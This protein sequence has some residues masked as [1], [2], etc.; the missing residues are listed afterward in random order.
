MTR[1]LRSLGASIALAL[2]LVPMIGLAIGS[3]LEISPTGQVRASVVRWGLT[4]SDPFVITCLGNSLTV[5]I[6]SVG[7]GT[8]AGVLAARIIRSRI[9]WHRGLAMLLV[10]LSAGCHPFF[11]SIGVLLLTSPLDE[12]VAGRLN[13]AGFWDEDCW[14]WL[15][16]VLSQFGFA[17]A[18]IC[19][20]TVRGLDRIR[21]DWVLVST[22]SGASRRWIWRASIWPLVRPTVAR[23]A[24]S[25]FSVLLIEPG[26]PIVLGLQRT[27]G[28]QV[29]ASCWMS[30]RADWPRA[31]SIA[32]IGLI[33]V[34]LVRLILLRWG[35]PDEVDARD[36][37]APRSAG[38]VDT[39]GRL[40]R[41]GSMAFLGLW[42]LACL[43]PAAAVFGAIGISNPEDL[44]L[45]GSLE[46]MV[47]PLGGS[48]ALGG[49]VAVVS[50]LIAWPMSAGRSG[51][52]ASAIIEAMPPLAIG[53]GLFGLVELLR[54]ISTF[55]PS[56]SVLD[57]MFRVIDL[58]RSPW[59][60]I[61]WGTSVAMLPW[62]VEASRQVRQ[63]D[64]GALQDLA[65]R[66]GDRRARSRTL[67]LA[68]IGLR[69]C[70]RT[71]LGVLMLAASGLSPGIVLAPLESFRPIGA[72]ILREPGL[73]FEAIPMLSALGLGCQM[74]GT[75]LLLGAIR[76]SGM[77]SVSRC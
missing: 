54:S 23:A 57:N 69:R 53:L 49:V 21:G 75:V 13:L 17:S 22:L 65:R 35:G 32:V 42:L 70:F 51:R 18:W 38:P 45:L 64:A 74:I 12:M 3:M 2:V 52:S 66:S 68:P 27:L 73:G 40:R 44:P 14:R 26:G 31:V 1:I 43:T 62:A 33:V 55:D 30:S 72:W 10:R 50:L 77:V 46:L 20:W 11:A 7:L 6:A 28:A 48:A 9:G 67:L 39:G 56:N 37:G 5:S 36:E 19:W 41:I 76:E 15:G 61:S 58:Y 8:L 63:V 29:V 16:L 4:L 71:A 25:A 59:L 34:V 47:L 60:L 24:A